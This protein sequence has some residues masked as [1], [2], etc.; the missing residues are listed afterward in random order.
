[1][2]QRKRIVLGGGGSAG[3]VSPLVALAEELDPEEWELLF[4]GSHTGPERDLVAR[5]SIPFQSVTTAKVRRDRTVGNLGVPFSV[6][7]GIAEARSI[8][9]AWKPNVLFTSGGFVSVPLVYAARICG[10]PA[11]TFEC[12]LTP[13]LATRAVLPMATRTLCSFD[14][15][16]EHLPASK[17]VHTGP[18]LRKRVREAGVANRNAVNRDAA[19]KPRLV[20]FGG[21]LGAVHIN[22][23]VREALDELTS[24]VEI[25]HVC[26]KGKSDPAYDGRPGYEQ[27]EYR[28]DLPELLAGADVAVARAGANSLWELV[29][30]RTPT[31]AV[32]LS[33]R[34]SRGDQIHNAEYFR[35]RNAL[36][37]IQ[38]DDLTAGSLVS[39]LDQVLEGSAGYKDAMAQFQLGNRPFELTREVLTELSGPA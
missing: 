23:V 6:I 38:D 31:I 33:R 27:H 8:F 14:T 15:T 11:V 5:E 17:A 35:S 13:G 21:S 19:S 20:V 12:D 37:V 24:R 16:L 2:K 32:P 36:E 28:H 29:A 4:V 10:V 9:R 7:K 26:G 39:A 25:I 30:L 18:L 1:M 3:H 22:E 34:V